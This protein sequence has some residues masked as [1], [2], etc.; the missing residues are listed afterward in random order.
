MKRQASACLFFFRTR[1]P[2]RGSGAT[3]PGPVLLL[4]SLLPLLAGPAAAQPSEVQQAAGGVS[5]T[6]QPGSG[7]DRDRLPGPIVDRVLVELTRQLAVSVLPVRAV[8]PS[9]SGITL[10]VTADRRGWAV[11]LRS[12][13]GD[14]AWLLPLSFLAGAQALVVDHGEGAGCPLR[15]G[16]QDAE[17]GLVQIEL[18]GHAGAG[19]EP[20]RACR[21]E[22]P[23]TGLELHPWT[24]GLPG[25]G[26]ASTL[27]L[28]SFVLPPPGDPVHRVVPV[29]LY[30]AAAD[31]EA[32]FLLHGARGTGAAPIID[33]RGRLVALACGPSFTRLDAG[34]AIGS[35]ALAEFVD[36]RPALGSRPWVPT[37]QEPS[38]PPKPLLTP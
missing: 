33:D 5:S 31:A 34:L 15:V 37:G 3:R 6:V 25:S 18:A 4:A 9:Q 35:R 20:G 23:R 14:G 1:S 7:W 26:T 2:Q 24:D 28:R 36:G 16:R 19:S 32:F 29:S 38:W 21:V 27:P 17:L 11:W 13:S 30:G 8:A 12:R 10:P 22:P